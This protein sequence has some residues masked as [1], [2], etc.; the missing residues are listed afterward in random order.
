LPP[1]VIGAVR[2]RSPKT[3]VSSYCCFL[4]VVSEGEKQFAGE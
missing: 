2:Q 4:D 1:L 3:L